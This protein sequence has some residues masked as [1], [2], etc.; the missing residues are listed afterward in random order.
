LIFLLS[1]AVAIHSLLFFHINVRVDFSI[2]GGEC[3]WNLEGNCLEHK[4]AFGSVAIFTM[5]ILPAMSMGDHS[6]FCSL[7]SF[8]S[9]L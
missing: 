3:H 7:I 4:I 6:I 5:L 8:F 9:G 1:I 2:S